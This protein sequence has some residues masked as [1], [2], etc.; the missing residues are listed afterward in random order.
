MLKMAF[1]LDPGMLPKL[2]S[3]LEHTASGLEEL[4]ERCIWLKAEVVEEDEFE[5]TGRRAILNFGHTVAHA[6]EKTNGY[7]SLLHG[8]AVAIGMIQEARLGERL[9]VTRL[10]TAAEVEQYVSLQGLPRTCEE[11]LLKDQLLEAMKL[12]KKALGG[13]LTFSLLEEPGKCKLVTGVSASEV[14]AVLDEAD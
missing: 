13:E 6:L 1:I 12:D 9:G 8:E 2:G 3:R 5:T 14:L 7:R 10:G 11:I 4:I